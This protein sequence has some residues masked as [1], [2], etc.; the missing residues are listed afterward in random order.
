MTAIG[1]TAG[2]LGAAWAWYML[3]PSWANLHPTGSQPEPASRT[4]IK[5]AVIMTDGIFN[6]SHVG[7]V[8]DAGSGGYNEQSYTMFKSLC[9]GMKA[10]D[11]R[12]YTVA[13]DLT[14]SYALS[15]L[16]ECAGANA[17]TASTSAQLYEVFRQ[18]GTDINSIRVT[19]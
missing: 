9:D 19:R 13:F 7:G 1:G 3:S 5:T 10:Q 11:I 4:V 6:T 14:D 18:I 16:E 2:H 17:L 8:L 15:K 12:V